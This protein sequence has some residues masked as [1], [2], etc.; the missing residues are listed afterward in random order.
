VSGPPVETQP[1]RTGLA[2]QRTALGVLAIAGLVAHGAFLG[3]DPLLLLL[4]GGMAL[5]GLVLLGAVAPLRYR[6]L[7]RAVAEGRSPVGA[8]PVALAVTVALVAAVGGG[9]AVLAY[10]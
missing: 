10:A 7:Q 1:E 6:R 8:R 2:W 9:V 4:A 3:G 5:L